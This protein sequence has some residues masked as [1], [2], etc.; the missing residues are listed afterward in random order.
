MR[1]RF[2]VAALAVAAVV[3]VLLF[4]PSCGRSK[5]SIAH[6]AYNAKVEPLLDREQKVWA[7]L[8][9]LLNEQS[10][11]EE[12]DFNRFSQVLHDETLPFYADFAA[13]VGKLEPGDPALEPAQ[14]ALQR[15]A[16]SRAEF[17][18]V[19]ADNLDT[20]K[21][22]DPESKMNAKDAA[23]QSAVEAYGRAIQG[24]MAKADSRFSDLISLET[25]FQ[26]ACVEPIA[27]GKTTADEGRELIAKKILPRVKALRATKFTEDE[28]SRLLRVAL[29]AAEDFFEAVV[30]ELPRL[31]AAARLRRS[32]S[33][34]N[35]E[36]DDALKKFLE[37]MKLVR[38]RM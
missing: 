20:V 7:K 15:F 30:A 35:K 10:Q 31:E 11:G 16:K 2:A 24:D 34:L 21:V 6:E 23:L 18:R 12:P 4:A 17:A 3:S 32:S 19:L 28:P 36:G 9:T 37:E 22:G 33:L 5:L 8:A 29:G 14:S 38:G 27:T 26:T 1:Q 13:S 25:Q